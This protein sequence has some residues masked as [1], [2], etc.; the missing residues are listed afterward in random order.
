MSENIKVQNIGDRRIFY[1]DVGDMPAE[2]AM[3]YLEKIKK[4]MQERK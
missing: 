2:K 4:E 3:A 1:I